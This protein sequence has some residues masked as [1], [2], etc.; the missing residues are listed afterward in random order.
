MPAATPTRGRP[1]NPRTQDD[2]MAA[3][4]RLLTRDGYEQVTIDA[5]AREAGVSRPTIYRR[6]PSK[7]HV[8]FDAAFGQP[9]D[10]TLVAR[11]GDFATDLAVFVRTVLQFWGEPVVQAAALGILADRHRDPELRIRTQQLLDERTLTEFAALVRAGIDQGHLRADVDVDML[12]Q[13]LVGTAFYLT[14]IHQPDDAIAVAER[15]CSLVI[16]GSISESWKK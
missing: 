8:V 15:L 2:V 4:R 16:R 7:A 6:W 1:R 5:I 10:G 3:A 14:Q 9:T 13:T 11:S 12:Y